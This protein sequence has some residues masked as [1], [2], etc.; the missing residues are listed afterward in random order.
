MI[1]PEGMIIPEGII[2]LERGTAP[3]EPG[4][5]VSLEEFVRDLRQE[6]AHR[7]VLHFAPQHAG[8][9]TGERQVVLGP[10]DPDVC[11]AAFFLLRT[12][13]TAVQ[14]HVAGED[15]VLHAGHIDMGELQA[16]R[17]VERHQKDAV[18]GIPC[19]VEIGDKR[20]FL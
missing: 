9:G 7:V 20:H 1:F 10:R 15:A 12:F 17:A 2:V 16:L 4:R 11:K 8:T 19:L 6:P 5:A 14:G 3:G 13:V 18:I